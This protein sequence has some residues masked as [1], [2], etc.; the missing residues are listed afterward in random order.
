MLEIDRNVFLCNLVYYLFRTTDVNVSLTR[1]YGSSTFKVFYIFLTAPITL[2]LV[3]I[4]QVSM[5]MFKM[6]YSNI[7]LL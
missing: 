6:Y 5:K 1:L 7:F 3:F 4:K 2:R